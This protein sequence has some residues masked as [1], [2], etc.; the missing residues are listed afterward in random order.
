M[1]ETKPLSYNPRKLHIEY[2]KLYAVM[3][4]TGT[5]NAIMHSRSEKELL[6]IFRD[7]EAYFNEFLTYD[8]WFEK[9]HKKSIP[10]WE[11]IPED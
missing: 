9:F 5:I 8:Q 6:Y 10:E 11:Y 4:C 3:T 2:I 1:I 7:M